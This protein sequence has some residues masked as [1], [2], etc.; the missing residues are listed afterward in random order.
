[1]NLHYDSGFN[2]DE[3]LLDFAID[4]GMIEQSGGW[5]SYNNKKYRKSDFNSELLIEIKEKCQ[6]KQNQI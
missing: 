4:C 3:N 6:K 1:M 5:L 2:I